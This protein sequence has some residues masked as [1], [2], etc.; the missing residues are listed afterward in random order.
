MTYGMNSM[1]NLYTISGNVLLH[2]VHDPKTPLTEAPVWIDLYN[3]TP[4]EEQLIEDYLGVDIP[5]RKEMMQR[6]VSKRLYTE[7]GASYMTGIVIAK[8]ETTSPES[9]AVTFALY[10]NCL[11]TVRYTQLLTFKTFATHMTKTNF[12]EAPTAQSL[13]VGLLDAII[14]RFAAILEAARHNIDG[15]AQDIFNLDSATPSEKHEIDYRALLSRIGSTGRLISKARESAVSIDRIMTYAIQSPAIKWE[16]Q[17]LH[18]LGALLKDVSSLGD[19]ADFLS[20][21]TAFLLEATLGVINIE[22]NDVMKIFSIVSIIFLPPTLVASIYGMNFR[23]IPE[24][25]WEMGY[26]YAI[27]LM[28]VSALLSYRYFKK[29]KLL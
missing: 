28:F 27:G 23:I 15:A 11:I 19:Y 6:A 24:I 29:H 17:L 18:R 2:S 16:P 4:E 10:K 5:T 12:K 14:D 22:Q 1:I 7:N 21:E 25:D 9:Q 3:I 13:F 8:S 20:S 26:F